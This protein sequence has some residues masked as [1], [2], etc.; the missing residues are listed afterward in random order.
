MVEVATFGRNGAARG[1]K[2]KASG[3]VIESVESW[4]QWQAQGAI[5]LDDIRR[6]CGACCLGASC[7]ALSCDRE[8]Y[9]PTRSRWVAAASGS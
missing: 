8:V 7:F 1:T 5:R 4:N 9:L 6:R 3:V 2:D